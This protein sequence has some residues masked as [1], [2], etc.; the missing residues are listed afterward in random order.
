VD[1]LYSWSW[2]LAV[3]GHPGLDTFAKTPAKPEAWLQAVRKKGKEALGIVLML[4]LPTKH[5]QCI[6]SQNDWLPAATMLKGPFAT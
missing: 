3:A 6:I 5:P 4:Y 1:I 2:L